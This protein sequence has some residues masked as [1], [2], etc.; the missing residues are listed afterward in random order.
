MGKWLTPDRRYRKGYR[1]TP[2]GRRMILGWCAF[3][4]VWLTMASLVSGA[5]LAG[6]LLLLTY[7]GLAAFRASKRR[8]VAPPPRVACPPPASDWTGTLAAPP[9]ERNSRYIPQSV[10]I[11]VTQ[12]DGGRCRQCGSAEN[13]HYDHVIPHSRGGANTVSN[14]QLLC[15]GC[16]LRKGA[17]D[18]PV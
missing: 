4:V 18:T 13:L 10:K 3:I 6:L 11:A 12:R 5:G 9:G 2:H 17:D 14:I 16:N 15:G 8:A 1:W 7:G